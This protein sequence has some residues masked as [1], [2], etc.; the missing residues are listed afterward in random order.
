ML[1]FLTR[2]GNEST[3]V[4]TGDPSQIDLRPAGKSGLLEAKRLLLDVEG[5][6]FVEFGKR[7]VIRHPVVQRIIDA[8]EGGRDG[9]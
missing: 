5:I 4:I 6:H 8:Y 2:L 9:N 7:D 1:M 3:C